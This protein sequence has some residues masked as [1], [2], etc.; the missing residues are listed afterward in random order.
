MCLLSADFAL[1]YVEGQGFIGYGWKN[2]LTVPETNKWYEAS[3]F[4][5]DKAKEFSGEDYFIRD[6]YTERTSQKYP[7]GY[8]IFLDKQ[9]AI[10]YDRS[11]SKIYR[12][13]FSDILAFGK[14][15]SGG[16]SQPCIIAKNIFYFEAKSTKASEDPYYKTYQSSCNC[17]DCEAFRKK[18][19][20]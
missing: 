17:G 8:H 18:Y 2:G 20:L 12:V 3:G 7:L 1:E 16:V 14:N 11:S 19:Y 4:K 9:H 6:G 13:A 5:Y 10:N 15:N